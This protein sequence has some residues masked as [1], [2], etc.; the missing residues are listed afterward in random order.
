MKK[1]DITLGT[2]LAHRVGDWWHQPSPVAVLDKATLWEYQRPPRGT[3]KWERSD[4]NRAGSYRG[5]LTDGTRYWGYLAV[6][7][8]KI[9][10]EADSDNAAERV[11][12]YVGDGIPDLTPEALADAYNTMPDGLKLTVVDSRHLVGDWDKTIYNDR[13][14]AEADAA[15]RKA[16]M[17]ERQRRSHLSDRCKD[18]WRTRFGYD[19]E[20]DYDPYSGNV[21][22][23]VDAL[24]ALL[25]L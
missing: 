15:K 9:H 25:N 6:M 4:Y 3:V 8:D 19:H 5:F 13:R 7:G 18:Q 24:A 2:V 17:D 20:Y 12:S 11:R 1:A 10:T 23:S 14:K 22:M 21:R 16:E